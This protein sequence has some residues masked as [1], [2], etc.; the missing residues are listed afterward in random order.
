[1]K[2]IFSNSLLMPILLI[3]IWIFYSPILYAESIPGDKEC[4]EGS[5][6]ALTR[7]YAKAM[8]LFLQ[9]EQLGNP[10]GETAIGSLYA[11]GEGV[12]QDYHE[13]MKWYLKAAAHGNVEANIYIGN[14]YGGGYGVPKDG[15]ECSKWWKKAEEQK[16]ANI[17][18]RDLKN[19]A[20]PS[21]IVQ[22]VP[23]DLTKEK[24]ELPVFYIWRRAYPKKGPS[25]YKLFSVHEDGTLSED[26]KFSVTFEV[27]L[28][29]KQAKQP[30]R[31][32]FASYADMIK[33]STP[34]AT[35]TPMVSFSKNWEIIMP[36]SASENDP[37]VHFIDEKTSQKKT[38]AM[39]GG[40]WFWS[41]LFWNPVKDLFYLSE[42]EG[43]STDR[44]SDYYQFDP[45]TLKFTFIGG[46]CGSFDL[47][48][49][50]KWIIWND[51]TCIKWGDHQIHLYSIE[52]N[53]DYT[54]TSG[55]SDNEF[56]KWVDSN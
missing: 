21:S 20:L 34:T 46:G 1:M 51:G 55:H 37:Y 6:A 4:R 48:P 28:E 42:C 2:N 12:T 23:G 53:T 50:G 52:M 5:R 8:K 19:H 26:K 11:G 33:Y 41:A 29:E 7:D 44:H 25:H 45:E 24:I 39:P 22:P 15:K 27:A 30:T 17:Q 14:L 32:A 40:G 54:L 18:A 49:D 9:A 3:G 47:S 35:P 10:N 43:S 31:P 38:V 16:K 56:Y 36:S 13:A